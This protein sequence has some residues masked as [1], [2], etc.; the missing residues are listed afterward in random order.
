LTVHLLPSPTVIG[1]GEPASVEL[2]LRTMPPPNRLA[3]PR[4]G[5]FGSTRECRKGISTSWG[6]PL[7]SVGSH[8]NY[9]PHASLALL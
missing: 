2:W 8:G 1:F 4:R 5:F 9:R 3:S 7:F 6:I